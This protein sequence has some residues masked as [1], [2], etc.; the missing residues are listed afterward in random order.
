MS[1]P[2]TH[3][4]SSHALAEDAVARNP[5]EIAQQLIGLL[6]GIALAFLVYALFPESA[7]STVQEVAKPDA[8]IT[9]RVFGSPRPSPSS[10]ACGG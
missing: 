7:V 5:G 8:E 1:T 10:W 4:S 2:V 6:V 3:E 9:T